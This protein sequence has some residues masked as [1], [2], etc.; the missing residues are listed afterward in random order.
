MAEGVVE[1]A[2]EF[3]GPILEGARE[4]ITNGWRDILQTRDQP[5]AG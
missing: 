2:S 1:T 3:L 5:P 4:G